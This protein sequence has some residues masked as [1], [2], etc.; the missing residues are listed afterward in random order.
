MRGKASGNGL[1]EVW[2]LFDCFER[3]HPVSEYNAFTCD[4]DTFACPPIL[5]PGSGAKN[6]H[7]MTKD[8]K[9]LRP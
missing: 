4:T 7:K 2:K 5:W 3:A 1:L 9:E 6:C 8:V